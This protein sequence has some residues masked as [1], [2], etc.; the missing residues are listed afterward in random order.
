[1][2]VNNENE[3]LSNDSD[4]DFTA[5]KKH[6]KQA[7]RI[8]SDDSDNENFGPITN[9]VDTSNVIVHGNKSDDNQSDRIE[10][11]NSSNESKESSDDE[12]RI[13]SSVQ[14]KKKRRKKKSGDQEVNNEVSLFHSYSQTA[15]R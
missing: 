1:M 8:E 4:E 15:L 5:R 9:T 7:L 14:R 12:K 10:S 6:G 3:L 11:E 2:E 13:S